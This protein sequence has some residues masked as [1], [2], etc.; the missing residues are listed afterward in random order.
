MRPH[1]VLLFAGLTLVGGTKEKAA[2]AIFWLL[3]YIVAIL[4]AYAL[5]MAVVFPAYL[6]R[7]VPIASLIYRATQ[8]PIV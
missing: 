7:I 3:L 2:A 8:Y 1:N 5:V 4:L 6:T